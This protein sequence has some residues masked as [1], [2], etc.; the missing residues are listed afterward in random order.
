MAKK[1]RRKKT[2]KKEPLKLQKKKEGKE[3][4][5]IMLKEISSTTIYILIA[6]N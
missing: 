2:V 6:L 5:K 1:S 4:K 3:I